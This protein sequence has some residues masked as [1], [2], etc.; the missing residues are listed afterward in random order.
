MWN[1]CV[2]S[3]FR[4]QWYFE[5]S[6]LGYAEAQ[7]EVSIIYDNVTGKLISFHPKICSHVKD[8]PGRKILFWNI[9]KCPQI[10]ATQKR[11]VAWV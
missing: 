4:S 3:S 5:F 9:C 6:F 1:L 8:L 10:K 2:L 7:Y 11:N